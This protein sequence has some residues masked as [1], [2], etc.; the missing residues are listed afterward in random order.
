MVVKKREAIRA[1]RAF[2]TTFARENRRE[3]T[4]AEHILWNQL[5]NRRL[6]GFKFRREYPID[7][8]I[9]DFA[10]LEKRL[11]VELDGGIHT[12]QRAYDALRERLI[13]DKGFRVM[14]FENWEMTADLQ[15]VLARIL[16]CVQAA[17]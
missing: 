13:V 14:R 16:T 17:D 3:P 15:G 7:D 10:C 2:L 11:I 4:P 6:G 1:D 5:R 9:A 8:Y 12:R